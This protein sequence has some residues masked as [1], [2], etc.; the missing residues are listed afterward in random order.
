MRAPGP[1]H[2]V[3]RVARGAVRARRWWPLSPHD[4]VERSGFE[5]FATGVEGLDRI[6]RGGFAR[7]SI[8][9][10]EGAPGT[11][12][13][14]LGMEFVL[15]GAKRFGEPGLAVLFDSS[16]TALAHAAAS[17][18]WELDVLKAENR[19]RVI[20]TTRKI[21]VEEIHQTDSVLREEARAI[22][23][24]RLFID[25]LVP[26]AFA[27]AE[28]VR[29]GLHNLAAVL[30]Q[31]QLTTML[32]LD[33]PEDGMA[34]PAMTA[35]E[36][37]ADMVIRLR[38]GMDRGTV[39]RSIEIVKSRSQ[40]CD[41]GAHRLRIVAGKGIEI[42]PR[43][44]SVRDRARSLAAGYDPHTRV[45]TGIP[46]L[47]ALVNGGL[48]LASAT[49]LC[50]PAGTGKSL[51]GLQFLADGAR[52]GEP[53]MLLSIEEPPSQVVANAA[54][55]GIDLPSLIAQGLLHVWYP[56]SD[57]F[58]VDPHFERLEQ[59]L[60]T[61][62]PRRLVVDSVSAYAASVDVS[63]RMLRDLI[64]SAV[65]ILKTHRVTSLYIAELHAVYGLGRALGE[66]APSSLF[67]NI[68]TL[69]RES[70]VRPSRLSM[71]IVKLRANPAPSGPRACEIVSGVG[72]S[73]QPPVA[74]QDAG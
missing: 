66:M 49:L 46:G 10:A 58:D 40:A 14:L 72:L 34:R 69:R 23:A 37:V 68:V 57:E 21:F 24:R 19:L 47:D 25:G 41:L 20:F 28:N 44:Q 11:G 5:L 2:T 43:V 56:E 73:V 48:F 13:S 63:P 17:F 7:Q 38:T 45:P 29:D 35:A 55:V 32:A 31:E 1:W 52:R 53:G 12:K 27:T 59:R 16:P 42:S 6:L 18:G 39:T 36:L 65:G 4:P 9:L 74:A 50:G 61:L 67:D 71:E 60:Q 3:E 26:G 15:S 62:R 54:A 33:V 30:R 8:I 70:R 64:Q 22:G 51:A